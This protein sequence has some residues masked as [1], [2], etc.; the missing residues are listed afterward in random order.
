MS[1]MNIGFLLTR[2][3]RYRPGHCA[4]PEMIMFI[5]ENFPRSSAGKTLKRLLREP[6]WSK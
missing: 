2:N 6:Y 3:V 5:M 1:T 4:P